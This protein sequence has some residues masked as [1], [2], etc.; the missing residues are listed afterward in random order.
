MLRTFLL[1]FFCGIIPSGLVY[2]S[3]FDDDVRSEAEL[4]DDFRLS[5][6]EAAADFRVR[7]R[8]ISAVI[9]PE[10][11][12]AANRYYVKARNHFV[13]MEFVDAVDTALDGYRSYP[14]ANKAPHLA[15]VLVKVYAASGFPTSTRRWLVDLWERYPGYTGIGQAMNEALT[16]AMVLR[17]RGMTIDMKAEDP[18]ESVQVDDISLVLAANN[19]FRFL[20]INGDRK[21]VAPVAQLGLARSLLA[22]GGKDKIFNARLAYNDFLLAYPDHPLVFDA[23]IELS[24]SHLITYRGPRFDVGVV[25]DA[26]HLINQAELYTREDPQRVEIVRHFRSIIRGWQQDRDLYAADWYFDHRKWGAAKYYY[27]E[28]INRDASSDQGNRATA[29]LQ[30]VP[31]DTVPEPPM[32]IV[33][34]LR[35]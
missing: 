6:Q 23:L 5:R 7:A 24:I 3:A 22:E 33:D 4:D 11:Q 30:E 15:H 18:R 26:A 25:L 2:G 17:D 8:E 32:R 19:I 20:A 14:Y 35:L 10:Y 13:R 29:A 31:S 34:W 27:Q 21:T 16:S 9:G 12:A 28:V 1:I